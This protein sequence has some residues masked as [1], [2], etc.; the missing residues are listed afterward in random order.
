MKEKVM[1]NSG[2]IVIFKVFSGKY[3]EGFNLD[4]LL[5]AFSHVHC[6]LIC[7]T[8]KTNGVIQI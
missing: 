1:Q 2:N 3:I 5:S 6:I 8:S 4:I 7:I